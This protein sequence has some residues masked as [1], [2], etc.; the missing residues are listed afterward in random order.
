MGVLYRQMITQDY[1]HLVPTDE[2][3]MSVQA[4]ADAWLHEYRVDYMDYFEQVG[5]KR[6]YCFREAKW[7]ILFKL[8]FHTS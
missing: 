4:R 5:D 3:D 6:V 2:Y 8:H 7:A 1:P